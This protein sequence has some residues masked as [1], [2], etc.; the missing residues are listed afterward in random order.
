MKR[1]AI[2]LLVALVAQP[3]LT[4]QP[5]VG[6]KAPNF[7]LTTFDGE[8]VTLSKLRGHVVVLDFWAS[9]CK[10]CRQELPFLDLLRKKYSK[11]GLKVVAV[12]I[13]NQ[14]QKA[15][16]FLQ[17]YSIKLRSLWDKKKEVVSAYD[18]EA[19]PTT[20]IIDRDGWIRYLHSG[21]KAEHFQEY[22]EQIDTLLRD[23]KRK[24]GRSKR[25]TRKNETN[26]EE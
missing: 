22:R 16:E 14:P 20:F 4:K 19:M 21:F 18:V 13:D 2:V 1:N 23:G 7:S 6:S 5:V 3:A 10:P 24:R 25:T 11:H 26:L 15:L 9:W 8:Q 12:N 17:T